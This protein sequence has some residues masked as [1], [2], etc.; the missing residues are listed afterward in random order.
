VSGK[1]AGRGGQGGGERAAPPHP[2]WQ[3]ALAQLETVL[4]GRGLRPRTRTAYLADA[5]RFVASLGGAGP[6]AFTV[7]TIRAYLAG[8]AEA[9]ASPAT[10][11][12]ALASLRALG[13]VLRRFGYLPDN[14]AALTDTP[15]RG[16]PLPAVPTAREV[17]ELLGSLPGGDPLELRDR[18]LFEV[19]Y[20][21]GLRAAE[22]CALKVDDVDLDGEE[23]RVLGKG[24]KVRYV[25]LGEHARS[26]LER[27]LSS[28]RGRLLGGGADPGYLFLSRNGRPL[29]GSDIRRRLAAALRRVGAAGRFTPHGLRHA[30]A[31][32]LL[33][34]GAD[35]RTIQELLGHSTISTTQIYTHTS[36]AGLREAYRRAHPRA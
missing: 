15:R 2:R 4:A 34:G 32:H 30:F 28:G 18:A 27:Y 16:R 19:A 24:G 1:P 10:R 29:A 22:L 17:A 14:P 21:C 25:P 5:R 11:A 26:W 8:L 6:Q 36:L 13:E 23:V 12:R 3:E 31:T 7:R 9:G 33:D 20:G 35:L